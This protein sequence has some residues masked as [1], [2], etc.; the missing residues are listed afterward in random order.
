MS[1]QDRISPYNINQISDENKEYQFGD[2][3]LIQ[4][5]ILL[6]NIT[7][8]VWLKVKRTINLN[9]EFK[10]CHATY[11]LLKFSNRVWVLTVV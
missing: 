8:I 7:R 9:R 6:T 1:D 4:Y 3:K 2:N 10:G 5:L 11:T